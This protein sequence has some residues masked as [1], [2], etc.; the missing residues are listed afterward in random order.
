MAYSLIKLDNLVSEYA[1]MNVYKYMHNI[2]YGNWI[3]VAEMILIILNCNKYT[4]RD[5]DASA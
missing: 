2:L 3:E 5:D 1:N 4:A